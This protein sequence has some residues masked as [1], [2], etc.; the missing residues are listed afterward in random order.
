MGSLPKGGAI[1]GSPW[2]S[3]LLVDDSHEPET[4][5]SLSWGFQPVGFLGKRVSSLGSRYVCFFTFRNKQL[6]TLQEMKPKAL[7][8]FFY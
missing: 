4:P 3:P 2:M 1:V 6:Q 7:R 8:D 5:P